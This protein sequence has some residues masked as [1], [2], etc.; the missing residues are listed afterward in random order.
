VHNN[1]RHGIS[2]ATLKYVRVE[3]DERAKMQNRRNQPITRPLYAAAL[4]LVAL[5][6]PGVIAYRRRQKATARHAQE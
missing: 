1:K 4:I 3:P 6:L 2:R 5:A